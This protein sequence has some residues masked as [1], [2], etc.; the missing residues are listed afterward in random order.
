M[1]PTPRFWKLALLGLLFPVVGIFSPGAEWLIIPWNLGLLAVA[2]VTA[3]MGDA[4]PYLTVKRNRDAIFSVRVANDVTLTLENESNRNLV[5]H[6]MDAPSQEWLAS[7]NEQRLAI[8]AGR[9]AKMQYQVVPLHRGPTT[10]VGPFVR[11]EAPLGLMYIQREL[12]HSEEVRVYPN[13]K[14]LR[15]FE[16]LKQRGRLNMIG[17]RRSR[18]KGLGTEFESL[19]DYNDDDFRR[20][21]WKGTARRGKLV[22]RNYET[23]RNQSVIV[24]FDIGRHMLGEVEGVRKID[25]A[26]DASLMLMRA[27][28]QAGDQVGLLLF[29]DL[30]HRYIAPKKGRAHV[31]A[32]TEAIHAA[33]AEPVQPRYDVAVAYLETKWKRRSLIV[34]FTDAENEDQARELAQALAPIRRRHLVYV[35]RVSDPRLAELGKLAIGDDRTFYYRA[36]SLWYKQDRKQASSTLAG[37]GIQSLEAEPQDLAGALVNAYMLVKERNLL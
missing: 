22:V 12:P 11:I 21:D 19:R 18:V 10:L 17:I 13:V 8:P 36:A 1:I 9:S 3:R 24:A 6:V 33:Q 23:E 26:F 34:V 5:V 28:E 4:T 30:V 37:A 32:I 35:V 15:E 7:G 2:W 31:S 14:A 27:A 16:L 29:N 20:I 25:H